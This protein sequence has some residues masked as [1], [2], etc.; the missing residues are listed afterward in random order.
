M[1]PVFKQRVREQERFLYLEWKRS[2]GELGKFILPSAVYY[3][4]PFFTGIP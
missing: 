1:L 3:N 4:E 2:W